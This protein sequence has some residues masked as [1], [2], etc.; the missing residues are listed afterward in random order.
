MKLTDRIEK[1]WQS[2]VEA[3]FHPEKFK[4]ESPVPSHFLVNNIFSTLA[5]HKHHQGAF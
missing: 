2:W 3:L 1:K 4:A 5:A